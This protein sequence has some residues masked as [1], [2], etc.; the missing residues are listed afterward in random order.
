MKRE[1]DLAAQV[2]RCGI[3][4]KRHGK[5]LI[6]LCPFHDDREPSLVITPKKN[7][8]NCLGACGEGGSV[9]DWVMKIE[10]TSFR[11]AVELLRQGWEPTVEAKVA[12]A[13]KRSTK[14]K[15]EPLV[16]SEMT[17]EAIMAE[18]VGFY[19]QTLLESPDALDYLA[20]RGLGS[21]E[22]IEHFQI[23]FANRTLGYRV[24]KRSQCGRSVERCGIGCKSWG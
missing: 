15:M 5:D 11:M 12:P 16:A 4:L 7:L 10:G 23:G 19:H 14:L 13:V 24:P 18:V 20:Q 9:I 3:E 1:V 17:D 6:G 8:W 2:R 22:L 21:K